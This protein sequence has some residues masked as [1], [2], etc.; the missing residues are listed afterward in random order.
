MNIKEKIQNALIK[1]KNNHWAIRLKSSFPDKDNFDG[2]VLHYTPDIIVINEIGDFEFNGI[3]V[4]NRNKIVG[5][6]DDAF[7]ECE[8]EIIRDNGSIKELS[9]LKWIKNISSFQDLLN[10]IKKKGIWP[11]V[12]MASKKSN[13]FYLGPVTSVGQKDFSL[14]CYD[15][16]GKW[17]K[18]YG[19][20]YKGI[21]KVEF[22]SKYTENFNNFM[23]RNNPQ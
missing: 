15:A 8:N 5:V 6:R 22:K 1:S 11:G 17:E 16:E 14:Y 7:E 21:G 20:E 23:K 19:L 18:E 10:V 3:V 13:A 4:L 12:E 9:K 2:I